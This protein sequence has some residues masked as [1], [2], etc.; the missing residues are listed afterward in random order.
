MTEVI[1]KTTLEESR[2]ARH[3]AFIVKVLIAAGILSASTIATVVVCAVLV[4]SYVGETLGLGSGRQFWAPIE[5]SLYKYADQP[6]LPPEKKAKII[7]AL[8]KIGDKNRPFIDA[9]LG[10]K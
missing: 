9:L 8:K 6:D 1:E 5:Q 10:S 2:Q 4:T 3:G 7:A